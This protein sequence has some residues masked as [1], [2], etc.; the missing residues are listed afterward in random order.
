MFGRI[1]FCRVERV[2]TRDES[3]IWRRERD[4]SPIKEF[5]QTFDERICDA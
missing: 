2:V 3:D 4:A 1:A 5:H